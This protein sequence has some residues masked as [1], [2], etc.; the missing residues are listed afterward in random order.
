MSAQPRVRIFALG[1]RAALV[2]CS[3][4]QAQPTSSARAHFTQG[5]EQAQLGDFES[6]SANFEEAYRLSP[7]YA[8][9]YNLGQAYA[10][11]GKS[12]E[13]VRAFE[14]YLE[15][16][17]QKILPERQTEVRQLILLSK[18]RV[19]YVAFEIEPSGA[20]LF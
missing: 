5:V 8:V 2:I 9:L 6:A 14:M 10:A 16:G 17:G 3:T 15:S 19:G 1:L 7:H 13:A 12:I 20:K 11:L 4:A 18:K